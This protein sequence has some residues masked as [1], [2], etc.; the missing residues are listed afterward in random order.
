MKNYKI[1]Y[2][3]GELLVVWKPSG[4]A[5]QSARPSAPDV[6]SMLRNEMA[7]RGERHPY[8]GLVNRLDQPVE[9]IFLVARTAGASAKLDRQISD[10]IHTEKWYQAVVCGKPAEKKG[11]LVDNLLKDGRTNTSRVVPAGTKGAKRCELSYE[12]EEEWEEKS[13]LKIRLLTG[14]HHQIR[15]QLAHAGVP[16]AGDRKYGKAEP[17]CGQLCL[18]ACRIRFVHPVTKK[19]M[20]VQVEP[21]FLISGSYGSRV[22][23][24]QR[25]RPQLSARVLK[26]SDTKTRWCLSLGQGCWPHKT[27]PLSAPVHTALQITEARGTVR[28]LSREP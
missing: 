18:C 4:I 21:T 19:E 27:A 12:V 26:V 20:D 16:I 8:L 17:G 2:E 25:P 15:V 13:L 3:D 1:L 9:G 7:E 11:V 14:R 24:G 6:M 10:H 22:G 28:H 5:V 23:G